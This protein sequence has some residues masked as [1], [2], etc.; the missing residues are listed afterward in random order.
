MP[1]VESTCGMV[2]REVALHPFESSPIDL[3]GSRLR[4]RQDPDDPFDGRLVD[5]DPGDLSDDP[6][7]IDVR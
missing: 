6:R 2:K 3:D 4:R 1:V 7:L 5:P